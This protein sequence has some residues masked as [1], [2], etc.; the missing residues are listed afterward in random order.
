MRR[1]FVFERR[2]S[3]TSGVAAFG[4]LGMRRKWNEIWTTTGNTVLIV[5]EQFPSLGKGQCQ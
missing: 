2:H 5:A 4:E 3:S 1:V